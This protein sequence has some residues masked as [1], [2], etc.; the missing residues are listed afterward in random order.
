MY[1]DMPHFDV[2]DQCK[3]LYF[4]GHPCG[5]SVLGTIESIDGLAAEQMREYFSTRYAP[6][7]MTLAVSGNFD[8]EQ[9]CSVA[10]SGC[11]LW[12]KSETGR[13]LSDHKGCEKEKRIEKSNL[14]REHICLMSRSVSAQDTR[15]FAARLLATIAGDSTGSRFFWELVDKAIAETAVMQLE[16]LDGT[17]AMYSY[18]RC[19]SE[20]VPK[21][22]NT[23]RGI[24]ADL[25]NNGVT[26]DELGKAKNKRL[27]ASVIKNELPMGR[28]IDLGFNWT[29]L[30]EYRTVEEDVNAFKAVTVNDINSLIK[31]FDLGKLTQLSM[32]PS[33]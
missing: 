9:F 13:E 30:K 1:Q 16:D 5:N 11:S 19:S 33:K 28:L 18:I 32:G 15:R 4:D 24:F 8:F 23:I 2:M 25:Y 31:E 12:Q 21:V 29:Y 26:D 6:N 10:E 22:M 3:S 27:S 20:N 14:S 17:G 7:N